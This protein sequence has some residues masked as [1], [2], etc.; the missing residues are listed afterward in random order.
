MA[1]GK[2]ILPFIHHLFSH[3]SEFEPEDTRFPRCLLS[4]APRPRLL[5]CNIF[6]SHMLAGGTVWTRAAQGMRIN[7]IY[8][9]KQYF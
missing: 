4:M 1:Q 6:L 7:S 8:K 9:L 5:F 2:N 3:F